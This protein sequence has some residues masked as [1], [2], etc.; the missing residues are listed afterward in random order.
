M[1]PRSRLDSTVRAVRRRGAQARVFAAATVASL[2]VFGC[3][4]RENEPSAAKP[5]SSSPSTESQAA[6][7]STAAGFEFADVSARAGIDWVQQSGTAEQAF[8]VEMK[9]TGA[10]L[11]DIDGDGL[12][13]LFFTAGSTIDRFRNG[14]PGFPCKLYRNLGGMR[15]EDV[16]DRAGIP[17]FP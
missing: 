4:A 5:A 10:A 7:A 13:D 15:F 16:S 14:E 1:P 2:I 8:I 3:G 9:S 11:L 6:P 12:L 17:R